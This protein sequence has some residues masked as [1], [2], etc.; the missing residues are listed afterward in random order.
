MGFYTDGGTN[1]SIQNTAWP[2]GNLEP[3][4]TRGLSGGLKITKRKCQGLGLLTLLTHQDSSTDRPGCVD[5]TWEAK[6]DQQPEWMGGGGADLAGF[7]LKL[8]FAR[9]HT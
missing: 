9:E 4:G 8:D 3:S 1:G 6:G 7:L 5:I 2:S